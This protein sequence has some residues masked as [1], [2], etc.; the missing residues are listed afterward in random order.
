MGFSN[1]RVRIGCFP[2][3]FKWIDPADGYDKGAEGLVLLD[4]HSI[5]ILRILL[6][7]LLKWNKVLFFKIQFTSADEIVWIGIKKS[8]QFICSSIQLR[9]LV[10]LNLTVI[11]IRHKLISKNRFQSGNSWVEPFRLMKLS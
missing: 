3:V 7:L 6:K 9:D 10:L 8:I 5:R 1:P 4:L 11:F 2:F